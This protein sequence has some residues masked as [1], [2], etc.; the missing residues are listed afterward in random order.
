MP[1]VT[2]DFERA[3]LLLALS[4]GSLIAGHAFRKWPDKIQDYST[5]LDGSVL[6]FGTEVHRR[7]VRL[8]GFGL[9]L[10]SYAALAAAA[11]VL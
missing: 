5:L 8:S 10:A 4:L 1:D 3:V 9:T 7:M 6:F 2:V 11:L